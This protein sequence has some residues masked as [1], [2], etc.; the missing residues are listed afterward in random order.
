MNEGPLCVCKGMLID[1]GAGNCVGKSK[2]KNIVV[3]SMLHHIKVLFTCC[4]T[5]IT[6]YLTYLK[7]FYNI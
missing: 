5:L 6:S 4:L 3:K 1:D 2:Y 7:P